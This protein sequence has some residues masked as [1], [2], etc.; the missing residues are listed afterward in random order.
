VDQGTVGVVVEPG[1]RLVGGQGHPD[2]SGVLVGVAE[3]PL[4]AV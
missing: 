3:D 1:P 4:A 2:V